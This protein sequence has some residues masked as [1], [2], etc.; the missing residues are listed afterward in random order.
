[1]K[2]TIVMFC[3]VGAVYANPVICSFWQIQIH[4]VFLD[5]SELESSNVTQTQKFNSSA[6]E[7]SD[8]SDTSELKSSESESES[9]ESMSESSESQSSESESQSLEDRTASHTD[10]DTR[11]NSEGSEE[12]VRKNWIRVFAVQVVSA[13]NSSSSE[14]GGQLEHHTNQGA[15]KQGTPL[16]TALTEIHSQPG[17]TAQSKAAVA[18]VESLLRAS[19]DPLKETSASINTDSGAVAGND[20]TVTSDTS[21]SSESSESSESKDTSETSD[22]SSTSESKESDTSESNESDTSE[23]EESN[24][25]ESNT[26][27][28]EEK[29]P[30]RATDCQNSV[31]STACDSEEEYFFQDIGD[32]AHPMD[33]LLMPDEEQR[34]LSL[35]R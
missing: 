26:S 14:V 23:S 28:S 13:E 33:H 31:N 32:D 35:R 22:C 9:L 16:S 19:F 15:E 11:D 6:S 34:E 10:G 27:E 18:V 25:S 24:T 30:K 2:I 1:M 29:Q 17:D 3:L 5:L 8:Q 7:S 21:D 12:N 4:N 20:S